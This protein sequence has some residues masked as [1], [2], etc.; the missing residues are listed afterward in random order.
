MHVPRTE[1]NNK[2][3]SKYT[4]RYVTVY[5]MLQIQAEH[6]V[7]ALSENANGERKTSKSYV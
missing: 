5:S 7:T 4:K 3:L 1:E 6:D 2:N